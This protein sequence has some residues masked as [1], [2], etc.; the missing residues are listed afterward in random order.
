MRVAEEVRLGQTLDPNEE[1]FRI[2]SHLDGLRLFLRYLP[3]T[4]RPTT[5]A[6]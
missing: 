3:P 1:R 6:P 2:P 4:R 5:G